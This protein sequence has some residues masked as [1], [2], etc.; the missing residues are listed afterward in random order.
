MNVEVP[1]H[2]LYNH[3]RLLLNRYLTLSNNSLFFVQLLL[4]HTRCDSGGIK[5]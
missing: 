2:T 3:I 4:G 5:R 1:S